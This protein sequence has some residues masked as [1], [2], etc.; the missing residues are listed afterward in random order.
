MGSKLA[1]WPA[2]T[3][4]L[5]SLLVFLGVM[6]LRQV[7]ALNGLEVAI[8]DTMLRSRPS[9]FKPSPRFVLITVTE[10]DIQTQGRWPFTDQVL[11]DALEKLTQYGARTIGLDLYR[12][13]PVPPGSEAFESILTRNTGIIV[14][15][16][17]GVGEEESIAPASRVEGLGTSQL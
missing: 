7:G 14:I 9:T 5:L 12:D 4:I 2:V 15:S 8:Y 17:F 11:A 16:K 3:S 6:G 10:A 13:L 1:K